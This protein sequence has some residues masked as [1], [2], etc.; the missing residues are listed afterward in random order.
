MGERAYTVKSEVCIA[1]FAFI[2]QVLY[3][4]FMIINDINTI[5]FYRVM[6]TSIQWLKN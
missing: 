2:S 3:I 5:F 6:L 1:H 4:A